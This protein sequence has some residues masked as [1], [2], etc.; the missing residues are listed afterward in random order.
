MPPKHMPLRHERS[1]TGKFKGPSSIKYF[2]SFR[3]RTISRKI[4]PILYP[5]QHTSS[6][7]QTCYLVLMKSSDKLLLFINIII[8]IFYKD[9]GKIRQKKVKSGPALCVYIY[10]YI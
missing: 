4:K 8:I 10:I 1:E 3:F 2:L 9:C 7:R 6:L 5:L